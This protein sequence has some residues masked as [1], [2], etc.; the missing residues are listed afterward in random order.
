ME[1]IAIRTS[2]TAVPR[3]GTRKLLA[4]DT[5]AALL[6]VGEEVV[7][8]ERA[9][10]R[11][12]KSE[13]GHWSHSGHALLTT[14]R[15]LFHAPDSFPR[16][17]GTRLEAIERAEV[18]RRTWFGIP[19]G[20]VVRITYAPSF[21][22]SRTEL[23]VA[24][25]A[26]WAADIE[27]TRTAPRAPLTLARQ[28]AAP[29]EIGTSRDALRSLLADERGFPGG[30]WHPEEGN[31]MRALL[32]STL[33]EMGVERAVIDAAA[34]AASGVEDVCDR[35]EDA[36]RKEQIARAIAAATDALIARGDARSF[37]LFEPEDADI[38]HVLVT[39]DE[40]SEL[41]ARGVLR[42]RDTGQR[43]SSGDA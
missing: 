6:L 10:L 23:E 12:Y 15:L 19:L 33:A 36:V 26:S 7:R 2:A 5:H 20:K 24:E 37:V 31:E 14:H 40:E 41:V 18:V 3:C 32:E 22:P 28:L 30:F 42:R 34:S 25:A 13:R 39:K 16:G 27:R 21:F 1:R 17:S 38:S 43:G 29:R 4:M 8:V 35:D 11:I 9:K